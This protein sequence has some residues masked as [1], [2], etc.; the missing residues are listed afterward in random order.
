M[1]LAAEQFELRD[2]ANEPVAVIW[3]APHRHNGV[4]EHEF[5]ALHH[6]HRPNI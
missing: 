6:L 2:S 4:V 1:E 3:C 5:M